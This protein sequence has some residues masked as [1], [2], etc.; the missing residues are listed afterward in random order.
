M[1]NSG[2]EKGLHCNA[3]LA[4]GNIR[5]K[6]YQRRSGLWA[7]QCFGKLHY[8]TDW[9]LFNTSEKNHKCHKA[10]MSYRTFE[11]HNTHQKVQAF[12]QC[13][14]LPHRGEN[15]RTLTPRRLHDGQT[16]RLHVLHALLHLQLIPW[17]CC[18]LSKQ[19]RKK[20]K[21]LNRV[22]I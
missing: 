9:M 14:R 20:V 7:C 2:I 13:Q 4:H 19:W 22:Y 11:R 1:K 6:H 15:V 21:I 12:T 5:Q 10:V 17:L 16:E 3:Q 18:T 8:R